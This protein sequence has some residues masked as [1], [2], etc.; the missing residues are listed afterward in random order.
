[1]KLIALIVLIWLICLLVGTS[2]GILGK[3]IWIAILASLI[4]AVWGY[5][6]R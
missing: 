3:V 6:H 2:F 5:L 4:A 1:M